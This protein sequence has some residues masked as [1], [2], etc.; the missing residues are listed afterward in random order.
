[1]ILADS[2][3][4]ILH[5]RGDDNAQHWLLETRA[6]GTVVAVSPVTIAEVTGGMRSHERASVRRLFDTLLCLPAD[7]EVADHAGRFRRQYRRSHGAIGIADYLIAGT[8][9]ANDCPLATLNI[10]HFPMFPGLRAPFSPG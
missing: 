10:R 4:L 1:M 8:A 6:N 3:V 7:K 5:L 2:D 9:V